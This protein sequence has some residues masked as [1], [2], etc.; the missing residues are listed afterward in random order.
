[1]ANQAENWYREHLDTRV[2]HIYQA[3]G[4]YLD[5]TMAGGDLEAGEYKFPVFGRLEAY[6]LTGS[7]QLVN[8]SRGDMSTV[9]VKPDDFEASAWIYTPDIYKQGP[10]QREATAQALSRAIGRTADHIKLGA[11]RAFKASAPDRVQTI[12]DG[13][14]IIDLP[15]LSEAI[16][17]LIGGS[18]SDEIFCPLPAMWNEQLKYYKEWGSSEWVGP[19]DMPLSKRNNVQKRTYNGV[20]YFTL[21]NEYFGIVPGQPAPTA[22]KTFMWAKDAMGAETPMKDGIP[23]FTQH[24]D[25]EGNPWLGKVGMAGCAVGIM[26][27]GV[28]ELHFRW[29]DKPTRPA[30]N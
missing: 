28:K 26:P 12:G 15:D 16:G 4:N 20:N 9:D 14:T 2:R 29:I 7:I 11:L 8:A 30:A 18:V 1:M 5:G 25:R 19:A 6:K 24:H 3:Q 13:S 17:T 21:P 23:S 27:E 10:N 22:I